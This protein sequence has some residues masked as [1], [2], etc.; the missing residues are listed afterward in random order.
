MKGNLTSTSEIRLDL[1]NSETG[2]YKVLLSLG[3]GWLDL[4]NSKTWGKDLLL[5]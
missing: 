1:C 2:G 4:C 3:A 5:L